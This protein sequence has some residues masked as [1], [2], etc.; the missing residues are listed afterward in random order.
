[1]FGSCLAL[2]EAIGLQF[3]MAAGEITP[4][5][6]I[7]SVFCMVPAVLGKLSLGL[8]KYGMFESLLYLMKKYESVIRDIFQ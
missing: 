4:D 5:W 1:M 6:R 8:L 7:A 3:V 2:S